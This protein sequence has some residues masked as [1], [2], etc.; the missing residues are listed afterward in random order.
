VLVN[1]ATLR[2]AEALIESCERCNPKDAE[3]PFDIIL[4]RITNSDQSVTDDVLEQPVKCPNCRGEILEKT[5]I[6]PK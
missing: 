4:D 6:E 5:L 2:T 1:A 3:I